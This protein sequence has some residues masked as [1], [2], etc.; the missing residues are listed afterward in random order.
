MKLWSKLMLVAIVNNAVGQADTPDQRDVLVQVDSVSDA[1]ITLGHEVE[2]VTCSLD[3]SNIRNQLIAI[4][5]E[6]VFN[7]VEDL[8]GH[9]R[10]IHLFPFL[11]DAL[12]I[13]YTGSCA[14][15][16]LVTSNK[17]MAKERMEKSGLPTPEWIGP[18]PVTLPYSGNLNTL[19]GEPETWII[20]SVWEHASIGLDKNG[21]IQTRKP[22]S[23]QMAM[24]KRVNQLGGSCFAERFING[25]E[26]NLS[27]LSGPQGLEVLPPAEIIFEGYG[28]EKL[29]IVDYRAKWDET[30]YGYH[31]TPRTFSFGPEDTI[32]ISELKAL[33]VQCWKV[34][35]LRGYARVDFRVDSLNRPWIL[36]INANPCLSPDAGFAAA[37]AHAGISYPNIVKR[38]LDDTSSRLSDQL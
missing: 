28:T 15:S 16:L 32:L 23:I 34:F 6:V 13:P 9:G 12:A 26:F 35:G 7:L 37:A 5:A 18:Y 14:E 20:K 22:E 27:L 2:T 30:S 4:N 3:L 31:H 33:A 1:L 19:E 11:L 21:L 29:R 36:E 24:K 10:L 25:R 17:I 8:E 38:I